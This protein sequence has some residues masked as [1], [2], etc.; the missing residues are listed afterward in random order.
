[1]SSFLVELCYFFAEN[2]KKSQ[3]WSQVFRMPAR[4]GHLRALLGRVCPHQRQNV[5]GHHRL[6]GGEQGD[7][8]NSMS[9]LL[10]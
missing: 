10:G 8:V 6:L 1:M 3:H 7:Q 9:L 5:Q 2:I 4:V